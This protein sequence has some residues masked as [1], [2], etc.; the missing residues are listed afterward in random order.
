M[1]D[2]LKTKIKL[3]HYS[4]EAVEP[5]SVTEYNLEEVMQVFKIGKF[6]LEKELE[7]YINLL[8]T[9]ESYYEITYA[10]Y[11][12]NCYDIRPENIYKKYIKS[13]SGVL[14]EIIEENIDGYIEAINELL[15]IEY[16]AI[17]HCKGRINEYKIEKIDDIKELNKF[18]REVENNYLEKGRNVAVKDFIKEKK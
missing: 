13:D 18:M 15:S 3:Y 9:D 17:N 2:I 12:Y 7:G 10:E 16:G 14:T 4:A 1:N 11:I 5:I 6:S 8:Q